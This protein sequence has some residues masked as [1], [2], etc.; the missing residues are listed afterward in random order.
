MKDA[1]G[2]SALHVACLTGWDALLDA[3]LEVRGDYFMHDEHRRLPGTA[4][5]S[6]PTTLGDL[7]AS[8]C[9]CL[10]N[11]ACSHNLLL[12]RATTMMSMPRPAMASTRPCT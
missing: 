6:A 9:P 5:A 2:F 1:A 8:S 4:A 7:V 12:S 3:L 10:A 11:L